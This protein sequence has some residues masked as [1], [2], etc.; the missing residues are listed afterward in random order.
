MLAQI[1]SGLILAAA[2]LAILVAPLVRGAPNPGRNRDLRSD[3]P[4]YIMATSPNGFNLYP[5]LNRTESIGSG[6]PDPLTS[7]PTLSGTPFKLS[8]MKITTQYNSEVKS[9][10]E[11]VKT[12][13]QK[14]KSIGGSLT[15]DGSGW[16]VTATATAGYNKQLTTTDRSQYY[17]VTYDVDST[18]VVL[19]YDDLKLNDKA[20]SLLIN[21]PE[22]FIRVYGRH[23]V[24]SYTIGCQ[25]SGFNQIT[26]QTVNEASDISA[27][28]EASLKKGPYS[29]SGSATF[30]QLVNTTNGK[31]TVTGQATVLGIELPPELVADSDLM[32]P[33]GIANYLEY[34]PEHCPKFTDDDICSEK[35]ENQGY[36]TKAFVA[37]LLD[38]P[39]ISKLV[40]T[41]ERLALFKGDLVSSDEMNR[42]WTLYMQYDNLQQQLETCLEGIHS[43]F[44]SQWQYDE[45]YVTEQMTSILEDVWQNMNS[46]Q[47]ISSSENPSKAMREASDTY[48]LDLEGQLNEYEDKME[49]LQASAEIRLSGAAVHLHV[50]NPNETKHDYS[51]EFP[52]TLT[53]N[54]NAET[55]ADVSNSHT[56]HGWDGDAILG[57][58]MMNVAYLSSVTGRGQLAASVLCTNGLPKLQCFTYKDVLASAVEYN[59]LDQLEHTVYVNASECTE[60]EGSTL[61]WQFTVKEDFSSGVDTSKL[62]SPYGSICPYEVQKKALYQFPELEYSAKYRN[63]LLHD[64]LGAFCDAKESDYMATCKKKEAC[65]Q[66]GTYCYFNDNCVSYNAVG[67]KHKPVKVV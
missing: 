28:L 55:I 8:S 32:N 13:S 66:T 17:T 65:C 54:T 21:D 36:I 31:T 59:T 10:V 39:A 50:T 26:S 43:C 16:G 9:S 1:C 15:V 25:L 61:Q 46:M 64:T 41:T 47:D 58:T 67:S 62:G 11:L 34:I 27:S 56:Y 40:N 4:Y 53:I 30:N 19:N 49:K 24:Q 6:V 18:K 52:H 48:L 20:E 12:Q 7:N 45:E 3:N 2:C 5:C 23:F 57:G 38:V 60:G 37:P 29:A 42:F 22:T 63:D 51:Y 44:A 33:S 14:S 35:A